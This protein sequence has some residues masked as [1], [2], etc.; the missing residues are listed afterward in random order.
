MDAIELRRLREIPLEAVLEGFGAQRDP[1]DPRRNWKTPDSR[2]TVSGEQFFDHN[3]GRGGG[4]ALDLTLHLMGRDFRQPAASDFRSAAR[5]LGGVGNALQPP[6]SRA[7]PRQT[8]SNTEGHPPKPPESVLPDPTRIARVRW[9]LVQQRALPET[10]VDQAIARGDVFADS[11]ANAVFKLRD[12]TGREVGYERRGTY[13]KPFHNVAGEKGLFCAGMGATK[14]AAFVESAI[15]ALSYKALRG[16]VLAVST[17]GNA[18]ELPERMAQPLRER[19]FRIVA[20]F[21]ADRDGDRFAERF[22]E[23]L[24][25]EVLRDRP[26]ETKDWNQLLQL[27]RER[28]RARNTETPTTHKR[29]ELTR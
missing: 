23:R 22:A 14:V 26:R 19:N 13:G 6:P 17:T 25:G 3:Q 29:L 5:W 11:K 28:A 8:S 21:N 9:Y 1:K 18:V 4:G 24:G 27:R 12:E 7:E 20:A 2:I 15:E 10:L 16:P